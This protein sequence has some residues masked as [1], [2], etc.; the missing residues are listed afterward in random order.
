MIQ[1]LL[2]RIDEVAAIKGQRQL[3]GI[4]VREKRRILRDSLISCVSICSTFRGGTIVV[5]GSE[6]SRIVAEARAT[7]ALFLARKSTEMRAIVI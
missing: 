1:R 5:G 3:S 4:V 6:V 7:A 2:F